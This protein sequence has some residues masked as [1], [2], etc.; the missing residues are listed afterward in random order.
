MAVTDEVSFWEMYR[1]LP[2]KTTLASVGPVVLGLAQ[3]LNGYVHDVPVTL[4]GAFA[5]VMVVAAVLVTRYHLVEFRRI[6]LQRDVFGK[7]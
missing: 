3:L 1:E 7:D 5:A 2:V 6:R 4:T